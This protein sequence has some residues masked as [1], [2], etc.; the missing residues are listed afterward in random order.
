MH[1]QIGGVRSLG[2]CSKKCRENDQCV[3]MTYNVKDRICYLKPKIDGFTDMAYE[4]GDR[5]MTKECN[6]SC[7]M[8]DIKFSKGSKVST[9]T[10]PSASYCQAVCVGETKCAAW[11]YNKDSRS[12]EMWG[13]DAVGNDIP[14][15]DSG[16]RGWVSGLAHYCF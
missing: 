1:R 9:V 16:G 2:E 13:S 7:H 4:F 3:A 12:C 5:T 10:A 8:D 6:R 15:K 11:S 14:R